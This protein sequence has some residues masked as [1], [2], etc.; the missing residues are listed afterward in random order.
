MTSSDMKDMK[1]KKSRKA[2]FHR[3]L[4][5]RKRKFKGVGIQWRLMGFL[6]AFVAFS[7]LV[8]WVFQVVM[9]TPFYENIKNQEM[10]QTADVLCAVLSN[11]EVL[12]EQDMLTFKK[13]VWNCAEEYSMCITVWRVED[14]LA[15][16]VTRADV[17]DHCI[18][19]RV[20]GGRHFVE[21][22]R[23]ARE[24]GDSYTCKVRL[25]HDGMIW[26]DNEGNAH[27]PG[28][29]LPEVPP[30]Q[31]DAPDEFPSDNE[32]VSALLM[33]LMVGAD[34]KEYIILLDS[35]LAPVRATVSTLKFQFYWIAALLL[36]FALLLAYLMSRRISRPLVRMSETARGLAK[37]D[38]DV[39]FV[40][41][42]YRETREL[43]QT[44]NFAADELSK[45]DRLQKEL[46][47]NIS[48]DLRTPLTMITGYGEVMRDLPGENTPEN[49]QV[50]I[51]E[52]THLSELVNDLLDLS[53]LQSGM[54]TLEY[55]D[56][57]LTET[58]RAILHRY[59]KLT[60][61]G[62]YHITFEA[63]RNVS[64]N[65]DRVMIL[66][67]IYNL[68]NNAINYCGEDKV[69]EVV[70]SLDE[71]GTVRLS[72]RDHGEGIAEDELPHIWDRYYKVDRVHRSAMIG[73]GLGLSIAKGV[74]DMHGASY[75][76][77]STLGEGSEFWFALPAA[78]NKSDEKAEE[79]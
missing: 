20:T 45:I 65:A 60:H 16:F 11:K 15:R 64:V 42:G 71:N 41:H 69:V 52:A 77:N 38:Y 31:T 5:C 28:S 53:R 39:H 37:G 29:T 17:S 70:Q 36:L 21:L 43:A 67:V 35:E 30:T 46:I 27:F 57:D 73:T 76:V 25:Y 63:E 24:N 13:A 26:M 66:Q 48:H 19:H 6:I 34:G 59:D 62:G 51:D 78:D 74:L 72:V 22:Y 75:G 4:S 50:I 56:F 14:G 10:K 23:Y 33:R 9:L 32:D 47:A 54:R 40:G 79:V 12:E 49:V 61:H 7:I 1:E 2:R 18:I 58:T 55:E 44:L 3:A 68:I 8:L